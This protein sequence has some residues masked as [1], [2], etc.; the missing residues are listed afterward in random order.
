MLRLTRLLR[1][2]TASLRDCCGEK[3]AVV[4]SKVG[5][6]TSY[7]QQVQARHERAS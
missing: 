2:R 1:L 6:Y 3:V 4:T 7:A 5:H